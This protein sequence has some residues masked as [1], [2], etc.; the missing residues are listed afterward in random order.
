LKKEEVILI[1]DIGKTA[2]KASIFDL[3]FHVLEDLTESFPEIQDDGGFASDDLKS[4]SDWVRD[5]FRRYQSHPGFTIT[6]CNFSSYGASLVHL[7]PHGNWLPPFYNYLKPLPEP[8]RQT[9][10]AEHDPTKDILADT[11]SP[12]L[13]MLNS[14]LQLYWIKKEKPD[15]F[16]QIGTSLHLPQYFC[17]IL[18]GKC[19]SDITSVGCHTLLWS[20]RNN[21]YHPW[22]ERE[23]IRS[24][25][26]EIQSADRVFEF[27]TGSGPISMGIGVHDSSAALMPYLATQA[28]PFLLLSSGTW[29]IAFNPFN[30]APLTETELALDCLCYMT[31]EGKPVK[32]SRIFLGHEHEQQTKLLSSYFKLSP[33]QYKS[34]TFNEDVFNLLESAANARPFFPLSMEGT[35]P[36]PEKQ[37]KKTDF[38]SFE[39]FEV[40]Y[41]QLIRY[42]VRWQMLSLQL[43]DPETAVKQ[44]VV[45]GGFVRN[46]L[47][48]EI[49]KRT[50][51]NR[52]VLI[53]DH[54]RASALGAAWLVAGPAGYQGKEGLLKVEAL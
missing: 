31:Y 20:F 45:V 34:V 3:D 17:Q 23:G 46:N 52:K 48:L 12:Y 15:Q 28:Q 43:I 51:K 19:F 44:I 21:A 36:M 18:T 37:S 7:D 5:T 41:H 35:G 40:A 54:P 50:A 53:S 4:V 26:P 14:G 27:P 47:F 25:F 13:G 10:F 29:N 22:V 1:F 49:L 11:A 6:H 16:R 8:V 42:L 9:F 33:D 24:L 32:A 2:K 30:D 39:N 38:T